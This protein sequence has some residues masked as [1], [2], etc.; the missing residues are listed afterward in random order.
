MNDSQEEN[1]ILC[2]DGTKPPCTSAGMVNGGE[3]RV[4]G[5]RSAIRGTGFKGVF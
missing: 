5:S 2:A 4:R 3:I 1:N